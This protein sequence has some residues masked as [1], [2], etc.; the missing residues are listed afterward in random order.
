MLHAQ[1]LHELQ[2][3][4]SSPSE[5]NFHVISQNVSHVLGS[6]QDQTAQKRQF[7]TFTPITPDERCNSPLPPPYPLFHVTAV[8]GGPVHVT[9]GVSSLAGFAEGSTKA[10][11][12]CCRLNW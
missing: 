1:T 2:K 5:N 4:G 6:L 9:E 8:T 12:S 3:N 10:A 11:E 7:L